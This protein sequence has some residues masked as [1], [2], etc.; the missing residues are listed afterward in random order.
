MHHEGMSE[1]RG[2]QVPIAEAVKSWYDEIYLPVARVVRDRSLL[3]RFPDRSEAD[4]YL[5]VMAN[6]GALE[7]REGQEMDPES[8]ASAFADVVERESTLAAKIGRMPRIVRRVRRALPGARW[9]GPHLGAVG[10][11][12]RSRQPS[13]RCGQPG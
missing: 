10:R 3:D 5:W 9:T 12:E 13:R 1:R 11:P 4:V 7:E 8:T 2:E 6:R